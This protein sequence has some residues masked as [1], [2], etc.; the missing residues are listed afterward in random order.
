MTTGTGGDGDA[1]DDA[2]LFNDYALKTIV[3]VDHSNIINAKSRLKAPAC[4]G[5]SNIPNPAVKRQ[6]F[7][8]IQFFG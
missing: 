2:M 8:F 3:H 1:E 7:D 4:D 5:P 6:G